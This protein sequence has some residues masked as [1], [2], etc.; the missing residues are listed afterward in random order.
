VPL[1]K[2]KLTIPAAALS[3][4]I[5]LGLN[6]RTHV[7]ETKSEL[8]PQP[9]LFT[10]FSDVLVGQDQPL[11]RPQASEQFDYEG[12]IAVVIG[13]A[14]RHISRESALEH[15]FGYTILHDGSVRDFQRHSPS[16]GKNFWRSGAMGP[17]IVTADEIPDPSI[18]KLET[19]LNGR[20]VQSTTADQMLYD[21]PTAIAYIS[22]W[23]PLSP[24]DVIATGTPAGV[25]SQH[26][27]PLWLKAGDVVEI[28]VS[29]VGV[30]RNPVIDEA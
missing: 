11:V 9:A 10:K 26:T 27:P 20:T 14:G 8:P 3:K 5:C 22:R 17:W 13:K 15:V 29:G 2:T 16:A 1:S 30:L 21:I 19:R 28:E 23:T 24:G 6:Y 25:G 12:E 18:L 4:F 7:E